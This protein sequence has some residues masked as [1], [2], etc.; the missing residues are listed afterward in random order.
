MTRILIPSIGKIRLH[1]LTVPVL[2][3]ALLDL[4]DSGVT[5]AGPRKVLNPALNLAVRDGAIGYN[6]LTFIPTPPREDSEVEALEPEQAVRLLAL[7]H[8]DN[9]RIPGRRGPN[10]DLHD[11]CALLLATG[12]RI[13]EL[14]AVRRRDINQ[15]D[16][17]MTVTIS[18]TLVEPRK[19]FVDRHHRK[20]GTKG[21]HDRT[22]AVPEPAA[23]LIRHRLATAVVKEPDAPLLQS[24]KGKYLWAANIRQR[25]R[26]ALAN[27]PE[28]VGT[29]PHTMRRTVG[30]LLAWEVGVDAA[31]QQLGHS[32]TGGTA[33]SRYVAMRGKVVDYRE[34]LA[35][36][37]DG[38]VPSPL[39][40]APRETDS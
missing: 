1:E 11:C 21:G 36:L 24:G 30:T 12:A 10:H 13:S 14:L 31:R 3:H 40:D 8:P 25:M 15:T 9:L 29:T 20:E 27:H 4:E 38:L 5:T 32:L 17:L 28:F 7:L 39:D 2:E 37:L 23:A 16:G 34:H 35:T 18:G 19:G 22:L 6:P 33:L 26:T